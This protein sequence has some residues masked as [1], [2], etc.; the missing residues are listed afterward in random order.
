MNR[1]AHTTTIERTILTLPPPNLEG[2]ATLEAALLRRRSVR[3]YDNRP[4]AARDVAQILW[5]AQGITCVEKGHRTA[6]S[7]G[8]LYPLEVYAVVGHVSS[9]QPGI[10]HYVPRG[11]ALAM[12]RPGDLR[13][14]LAAT[15]VDHAWIGRPPLIVVITAV[16][17]R[18]TSEYGQRGVGFVYMDAGHTSQNIQLQATAM[19]MGACAVGAFDE[20]QVKLVLDTPANERPLLLIPVGL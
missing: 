10:Y 3:E 8:A 5:A 1:K 20:A 12:V 4:I 11:H 7:A 2:M 13:R 14:E 18:T 15:A 17:E 16:F 19:G 6:P 9:L